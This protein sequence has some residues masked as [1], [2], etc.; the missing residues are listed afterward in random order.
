L[1]RGLV[2]AII[3]AK[4]RRI[5]ISRAMQEPLADIRGAPLVKAAS[6][7]AAAFIST[8]LASCRDADFDDV[9]GLAVLIVTSCR[10]LLQS[11]IAGR[12]SSSELALLRTHMHAMVLGYL[13]E[14]RTSC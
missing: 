5:E 4:C 3:A 2:D 8:I 9:N 6:K 1:A 13:K 14:M 11:A 7:R 12:A 10:A